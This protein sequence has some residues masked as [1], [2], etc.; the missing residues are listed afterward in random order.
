MGRL[1]R[2]LDDRDR[3]GVPESE[4]ERR[5]LQLVRRARLP[6]PARQ[7]RIGRWRVDFAYP[8]ARIAVELDG[9][10]SHSSLERFRSD[11]RRQNAVIVRGWQV[12]R[13]TWDDVV[14]DP[15]GVAAVLRAAL[16]ETAVQ[17]RIRDVTG[18]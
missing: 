5:F 4:L 17:G 6:Q 11:R 8:E 10:R 18:R 1:R 16:E 12:L 14:G 13:F 9:Y 3:R 2:L 15:S 7:Y